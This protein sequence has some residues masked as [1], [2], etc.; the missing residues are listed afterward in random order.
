MLG[1]VGSRYESRDLFFPLLGCL[2]GN[3]QVLET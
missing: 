2:R 1:L 3:H